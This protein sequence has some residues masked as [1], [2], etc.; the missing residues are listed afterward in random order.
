MNTKRRKGFGGLGIGFWSV[1]FVL[2][3]WGV[4]EGPGWTSDTGFSIWMLLSLWAL[5][6]FASNR[7]GENWNTKYEARKKAQQKAREKNK[8][9]GLK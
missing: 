8:R 4:T 1:G 9:V 6:G 5:W 2:I 3:A 7:K